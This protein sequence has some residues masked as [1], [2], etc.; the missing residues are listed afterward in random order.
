MATVI[1]ERD[2]KAY[3]LARI[4]ALGGEA[5][6]VRWEGRRGAPDWRVMAGGAWRLAVPNE[7]GLK[8]FRTAVLC[9]AELKAPGEKCEP[10]QLREHTRMR[11]H[12]ETVYVFD[13]FQSIDEV[14]PL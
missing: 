3:L 10:H 5:R 6:K 9:W 13:S 7:D 4:K 14:L 8:R 2:I 12:G 11:K 1:R